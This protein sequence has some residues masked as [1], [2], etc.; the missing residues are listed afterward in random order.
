LAMISANVALR[1]HFDR[2]HRERALDRRWQQGAIVRIGA[3]RR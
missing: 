1:P 2:D 3:R